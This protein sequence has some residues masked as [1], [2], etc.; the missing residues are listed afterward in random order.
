M[1]D[2]TIYSGEKYNI[3]V[4]GGDLISSLQREM[5][6][7]QNN[8]KGGVIKVAR[9]SLAGVSQGHVQDSIHFLDHEF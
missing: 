2:I 1:L 7:I 8:W 3:L 6:F 9:M 5:P 4:F